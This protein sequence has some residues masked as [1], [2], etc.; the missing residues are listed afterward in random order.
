[1]MRFPKLKFVF[2]E[3]T[4]A[5]GA[6]EIETADHQFERQRL[7]TE[8]Y[9]M[10]P[11]ELFHRQCYLTGSYDQ[12]AFLVRKYL[13][14]ENMLWQTNFPNANS[15]W[16]NTQDYIKRSFADV[17]AKERQMVLSGN[18]ANLYHI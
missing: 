4:L 14:I 1:M 15:T 13:G 9:D 6:Y 10:K 7:H 8:G 16:P 17:P 18:A 11:S 2:A 5:W 3:T 12:A